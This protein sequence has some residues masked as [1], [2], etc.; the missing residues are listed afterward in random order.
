ME[1]QD[2]GIHIGNLTDYYEITASHLPQSIRTQ[3]VNFLSRLASQSQVT[4]VKV[5]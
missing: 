4:R 1:V 2:L 5:H 3:A